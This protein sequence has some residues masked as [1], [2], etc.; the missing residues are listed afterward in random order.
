MDY[1]VLL[2]VAMFLLYMYYND[3]DSGGYQ[4]VVMSRKII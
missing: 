3:N 2:I 1:T 4:L